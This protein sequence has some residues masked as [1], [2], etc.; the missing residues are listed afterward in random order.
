MYLLG[1]SLIQSGHD[2]D[3]PPKKVLVPTGP[4]WIG[5]AVILMPLTKEMQQSL[6]VHNWRS[7]CLDQ[8]L[9]EQ[10]SP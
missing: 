1:G 5:E 3:V 8:V 7:L 4:V 6:M 2:V 9:T 10:K